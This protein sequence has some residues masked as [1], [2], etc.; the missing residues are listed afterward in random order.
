M[1][2]QKLNS[3]PILDLY[4]ELCSMLNSNQVSWKDN[5]IC[6][7]CT[8]KNSYDYT[9]GVGSL[10]YDWTNA[11]KIK[12][13]NGN[14]KIDVPLRDNPLPESAFQYFC[15]AFVDTQ[16]E[17]IYQELAKRYKLGRVRLMKSKPKTCLSWHQD[18]SKRLHYPIK[19]QEGCL[20][21]IED[22]AYKLEQGTWYE[23][24]TTK[25][26]TAFNGSREERIHLVACVLDEKV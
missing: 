12:D 13:K 22:T 3:L 19:T 21:V 5:Q 8:T 14:Q 4:S 1:S 23:T 16:F 15:N 25:F 18:T 11:K 26:H 20:M 24:D 10:Y 9:E 6:L 7:N 17:Q 2:C